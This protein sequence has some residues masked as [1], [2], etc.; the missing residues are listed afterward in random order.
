[1]IRYLFGILGRRA[2]LTFGV[3]T[4]LIASL[5]AAVNIT[6]RHAL[7]LYV[8][9]QLRR[10]PWDLAAYEVSGYGGG[11]EVPGQI[12][13]LPGVDRVESLVF[14]RAKLPTGNQVLAQ[15][16][17]Q[18]L[19]SPW[20]CMM[21][22]TDPNVLPP[23]FRLALNGRGA[24]GGSSQ[25]PPG[26][27]LALV[28]P[29]RA[30]GKAFVALQGG[31]EFR[32]GVQVGTD[33]R[34]LL[35]VPLNGVIRAEKEEVN[36]W[37]MDQTGSISFV[38]SIGVI[39]VVPFNP[40][41]LA[42]FDTLASGMVPQDLLQEGELQNQHVNVGDYVPE[43]VSLGHVNRA[44][45]LSG[46]D[47][48][49]SLERFTALQRSAQRAASKV[50]PAVFVDSTTLVLLE[51]MERVAR[52]VGVAT[53]AI[54]LPLLWMAWVLAAN[55]SGLLILNERRT[56]GLMRLR[57]VP[58]RLVGRVLLLA[59]CTGGAI[60]GLLG[61]VVGSVLPLWLYE[62][63]R[64]PLGVLLEGRQLVMFL[65]FFALTLVMALLMGRRFI[66]YATTIS[67]LEASRRVARSETERAGVRF[68]IPQGIALVLGCYAMSSWIFGSS[69]SSRIDAP[70]VF[71]ADRA[72]DFIG[73]PLFL[74]GVITLLVSRQ[75]WIQRVVAPIVRPMGGR[76][77]IF[78]TR[79]IAAKP[80]RTL[81]FLLIV[82][83]MA[84]ISLYP[85]I[86]SHSFQDRAV[87]GARVQMG[88]EW[89]L[90]VN[91]P[92]LLATERLQGPLHRQ[93]VSLGPEIERMLDAV[94]GVA[95]VESVTFLL[96]ALLPNF[97]MPG[98]GLR[99]V[100]LYL[101]GEPRAYP[102]QVYTE[103]QLG[104]NDPFELMVERLQQG[105]ILNS[106]AVADF[107]RLPPGTPVLLGM[108]SER[109][110]VQ[111]P[112]GGTLAFLPGMPPL[113]V[114]DRQGFVQARVDYL[115]YLFSSNTYVVASLENPAVTQLEVLIPRVILLVRTAGA[116]AG[117]GL[118]SSLVRSLPVAPLEIHNLD[119]EIGK[120]GSDMFI[121]LILENMRIYLIGGLLLAL[122]AILAVA[123]ANYREDQRTLALLRIRGTSPFLLR[124]FLLALL[125]APSVLGLIVGA[126]AAMLG[127]YG[128]ANYVWTLREIKN[129][130]H[131]L[132]THL[133]ISFLTLL[134]A[135]VLLCMLVGIG[136]LFSF[137][138]FRQS[139][140]E[141][142]QEG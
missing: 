65:L 122:I 18:P 68:G 109:D 139:A 59:I 26:A 28:G 98:Y 81:G 104:V 128:L 76:L 61:L 93:L 13:A 54:A 110:V 132:P 57:G 50:S 115:N 69:L 141:N 97:Y 117:D 6:S 30:M 87:R 33:T 112:S 64:L 102:Q 92:D 10:T 107:W 24:D 19:V 142:I 35:S 4:L 84:S 114:N 25:K 105:Q 9:D 47:I 67:P 43:V 55:L 126:L 42:R 101:V 75:T 56:L 27:V 89:Q 78:A 53:F 44:A 21:T 129:V 124:Q 94:R 37:L 96:E 106:P 11:S 79:H 17:G 74:Y 123:L 119:E 133:V 29:E 66:H 80:H 7:K 14:L 63:G 39:L 90:T 108:D 8:E 85:T 1:M 46:W 140:R 131:L 113:T 23:V 52:L 41:W 91:A 20:I 95:G 135:L 99:G 72:L 32:L 70:A 2:C 83:L 82:A 118:R 121:F 12:R 120:M 71:I 15:V 51:R 31:K 5:L 45:L 16:D 60:G 40:Q 125:L 77:G 86:A 3:V 34:D 134:T 127:G 100:P 130:V 48:P 111:A 88:T 36:R 58:G 137:W 116:P 136:F 62:G 103:A 138:V 49:G 73:L 22:A 38:P